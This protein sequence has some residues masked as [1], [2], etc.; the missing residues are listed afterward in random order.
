MADKEQ[1]NSG[2]TTNTFTKGM[3]KDYN[4]TFVGEGLWT[5]ARNAVNNSHDGQVGVLGNEPANMLCAQLPYTLIGSIHLNDDQWAIYTT[6]DINSEMFETFIIIYKDIEKTN[7]F[8]A[9]SGFLHRLSFHGVTRLAVKLDFISGL[10]I[11]ALKVGR[12]NY[13]G[14]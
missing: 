14:C 9:E 1:Q 7:N 12:S 8:F 2:I 5:H 11:K 13:Y 4:E 3:V 6:D 10:L